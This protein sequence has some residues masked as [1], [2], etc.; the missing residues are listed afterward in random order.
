LLPK[1]K[2]AAELFSED[3]ALIP[4]AVIARNAPPLSR[5]IVLCRSHRW[6]VDEVEPAEHPEGDTVVRM[7]CNSRPD[8]GQTDQIGLAL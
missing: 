6:L 8:S 3:A 1:H 2:G 5:C 7:A 4:E